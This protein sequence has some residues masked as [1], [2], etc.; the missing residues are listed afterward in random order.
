MRAQTVAILGLGQVGA[1]VGL[2]LRAAGTGLGLVGYDGDKDV[3]KY[4]AEIG[5]V[6]R[7]EL[8]LA[9]AAAEGDIIVLALPLGELEG[10]LQAIGREVQ[11]HALLVD[12]SSLKGPGLKWAAA[13]LQQGHYVGA[14]PV[15]AAALLFDGRTGIKAA[16]A[17]LFKGSV[18]CL[19][20]SP[21]AE[22]KAVETAVKLGRLLGATPFFL[23]PYEYDSLVQGVETVPGLLAA[24]VFQAVRQSASWRDILRF[25]GLP[26]AQATSALSHQDL[27]Y[28]AL[29]DKE[30]SLR[31]LDAVAEELQEVRRL[32]AE[33]DQERFGL[34]LD[35]LQ[36]ERA[37]WLHER[38]ENDWSEQVGPDLETP[39][40]AGRL[41]GFGI[42]REKPRPGGRER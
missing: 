1:S 16:R 12:L 19:M 5:A 21:T 3:A 30:A 29:Q 2:A 24:A 39:T 4:A 22:P 40:M 23:D 36:S 35:D 41:L 13:H 18:F 27:S 9:R 7:T 32:V 25:T 11:P 28:L 17:D 10:T 42:G 8:Y 6:D 15:L 38:E 33:G 14:S 26:F 20:P 31:W 34:I 37:R